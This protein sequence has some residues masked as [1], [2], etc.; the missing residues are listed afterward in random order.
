MKTCESVESL[1][2]YNFVD[3]T[4]EFQTC[5]KTQTTK[6]RTHSLRGEVHNDNYHV[7]VYIGLRIGAIDRFQV[8]VGDMVFYCTPMPTSN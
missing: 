4:Y 2:Q 1:L 5:T 8:V 3:I 6:Q 7:C